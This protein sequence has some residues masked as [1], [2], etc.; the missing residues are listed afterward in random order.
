[1]PSGLPNYTCPDADGQTIADPSGVQYGIAC[2]SDTT[3]GAFAQGLATFG[4][5]ECFFN[6][7]DGVPSIGQDCTAFTCGAFN[8]TADSGICY[9]K[10][11]SPEDFIPT[12]NNSVAA[13]RVADY[14][15]GSA[16]STTTFIV[17]SPTPTPNAL[18]P[19]YNGTS[20]VDAGGLAYEVYCDFTNADLRGLIQSGNST[21]DQC[22]RGCDTFSVCVAFIYSDQGL[23]SG[24]GDCL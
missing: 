22:F 1:M 8:G 17:P 20:Y 15:P 5:D 24:L 18:C 13:I 9:Y 23:D 16:S 12:N 21:I 6:F 4:F 10:H 7:S 11:S 19:E 2:G 3:N 14:D